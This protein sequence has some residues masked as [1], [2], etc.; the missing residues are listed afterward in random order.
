METEMLTT[1]SIFSLN[2]N[3]SLIEKF[4][5]IFKQA[6]KNNADIICLQ[7]THLRKN[8]QFVIERIEKR[9]FDNTNGI[10][11]HWNS[12]EQNNSTKTNGLVTIFTKF[13]GERYRKNKEI[14]KET[15]E[16]I[17]KG[18]NKPIKVDQKRWKNML[19]D[20]SKRIIISEK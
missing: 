9:C 15:I 20:F 1:L 17:E 16:I 19:E 14:I 5:T 10:M 18:N 6:R 4:K 2:I 8:K 13:S 12:I 11:C 7:E 3:G